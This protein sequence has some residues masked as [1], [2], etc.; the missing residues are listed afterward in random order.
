LSRCDLSIRFEQEDRSYRSGAWILGEVEAKVDAPVRCRRLS[1]TLNWRTHGKGNA[2]EGPGEPLALFEGDWAPGVHRYPFRFMA[3]S[4]PATYH[5]ELVN[6]DHYVTVRADVPW[7]I[8]PKAEAD[9]LLEGGEAAEFA[10]RASK[11]I[12]PAEVQKAMG[13]VPNLAIGCGGIVA[14]ICLAIMGVAVASSVARGSGAFG[15]LLDVLA[16]VPAPLFLLAGLFG[17]GWGLMNK[18]RAA[19]LGEPQV[20]VEPLRP[21][22]GGEVAVAIAI[23]PRADVTVEDVSVDLVCSETAT[24]GSGTNETRHRH[25]VCRLGQ[26]LDAGGTVIPAGQTVRRTGRLSIPAGSPLTFSSANNRVGWVLQAR[27]RVAGW[28]AWSLD[29]PLTVSL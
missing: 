13:F 1:A 24:S 11:G 15:I 21:K 9:I 6:V 12:A 26:V 16:T 14:V 22:A 18:M 2:D 8:D 29:V 25:E 3:P 10:G 27:V 4:A 17:V 7:A 20:T 28:P 23:S 5:G 19:R